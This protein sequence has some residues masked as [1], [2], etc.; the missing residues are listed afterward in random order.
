MQS[1][2][3]GILRKIVAASSK[4]VKSRSPKNRSTGAL[5]V[6]NSGFE[7]PQRGFDHI[8]DRKSTRLNSSHLG[9]SY[10]VLCLKKKKYESWPR[11]EHRW[12]A[13]GTLRPRRASTG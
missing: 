10:A 3:P 9:I 8:A 5:I 13:R 7:M 11:H 12:Q 6:A 4:L 1:C 2:A